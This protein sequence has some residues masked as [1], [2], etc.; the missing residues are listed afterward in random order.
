MNVATRLRGA[1]AI[2]IALLAAV[3]LYHVRTIRQTVASG[4]TITEIAARHRI[5]STDQPARAA[6]MSSDV[7]KYVV[8]HDRDYLI[9]A[10]Q[11]GAAFGR[12]LARFDSLRMTATERDALRSLAAD[13]AGVPPKLQSLGAIPETAIDRTKAMAREISQSLD[14]A[15]AGSERLG[16]AAQD[17][18]NRQ[19]AMSEAAAEDAQ[20]LAWFAAVGAL[21]LSLLMSALIA[22][23]ILRPLDRLARGTREVSAGRYD[24]RLTASGE[25]EFSQVAQ[26]F[27]SMTERLDELDRMKRDFVAKVSHDLK[28]PLSSMQETIRAMLDGVAGDVTPKQRQLLEMNLESGDRLAQ[29]VNKLLDLSRLE[30]GLA[31]KLE[32]VDLAT[33]TRQSVERF[34]AGN[35][36]RVAIEFREPQG[37]VFVRGDAAGLSQVVENLLEN[38]VKFSP[39][40]GRVCVSVENLF[41]SRTPLPPSAR[42]RMRGVP[43]AINISDEGPGVPDDEKER[44]FKRFYQTE[45][46]RAARGR[47]VGLGLTIIREIVNA[48]G[49][50]VWV[51]DNEP[52]GSIF[53]VVLPSVVATPTAQHTPAASIAR[54][55]S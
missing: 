25:D 26:D 1:F 33:L 22:R 51:S 17:A 29:M 45:A 10:I 27:N 38:A 4:Q 32:L 31:P 55:E 19:L 2:Y 28:T 16:E 40:D 14:H 42:R 47:G 53:H 18:M 21:A 35:E 12:A 39:T 50:A 30:A 54:S 20:R 46:G 7:E 23:S 24:Y 15:R 5:A 48:H 13:W 3:V 52:R 34:R 37:R 8:T 44:I 49:G 9:E 43:A 11:S 41:E 36:R 6:Q